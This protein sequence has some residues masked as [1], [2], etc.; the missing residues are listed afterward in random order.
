MVV[1]SG[2]RGAHT[3]SLVS[4]HELVT[5]MVMMKEGGGEGD[6]LETV[7]LIVKLLA[8]GGGDREDIGVHWHDDDGEAHVTTTQDEL[9]MVGCR[10]RGQGGVSDM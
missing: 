4:M 2:L 1:K 10:D 8:A 6:R 5:R 3:D 7:T 9:K